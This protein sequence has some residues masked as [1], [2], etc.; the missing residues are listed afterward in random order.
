MGLGG[1]TGFVINQ[2]RDLGPR[3]A[4]QLLPFT[5]AI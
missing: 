3:I 4:Y 5:L 2:A 1:A